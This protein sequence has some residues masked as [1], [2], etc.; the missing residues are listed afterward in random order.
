VVGHPASLQGPAKFEPGE[1]ATEYRKFPVYFP[2]S[3]EFGAETGPIQTAAS[4]SQFLCAGR[5]RQNKKP[6]NSR[7][8]SIGMAFVD[9]RLFARF[10]R[11]INRE[12]D[13]GGLLPKGSGFESCPLGFF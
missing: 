2:V 10:D 8:S 9:T 13:N 4:A 3:R 12:M 11:D 5:H 7:S 1:F 6:D